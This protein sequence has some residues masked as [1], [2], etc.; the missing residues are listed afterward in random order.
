LSI[1]T[2]LK[3]EIKMLDLHS[4][5]SRENFKALLIDRAAKDS[6]FHQALMTNPSAILD[7]ELGASAR[8]V[9]LEAHEEKPLTYYLVVTYHPQDTLNQVQVNPDEGIEST[10]VKKAWLNPAYKQE[11]LHNPKKVIQEEANVFVPDNV[12]INTFE[13][14]LNKLHVV[15][16]M[17]AREAEDRELDD[18]ELEAVAGGANK[19]YGTGTSDCH[20]C[21]SG[22]RG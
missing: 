21:A 11:L 8:Q 20:S 13:E 14:N 16:P 5:D 22:V 9:S 15:I 6:Q 1:S 4:V 19:D 3:K 12:T 18:M 2:T 17:E 10:V 7:Q